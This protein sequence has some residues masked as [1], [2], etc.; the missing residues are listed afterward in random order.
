MQRTQTNQA[1]FPDQNSAPG[2]S[3]VAIA[4]GSNLGDSRRI[5]DGALRALDQSVGVRLE[6][7]SGYYRTAPVGPPQPDYLNACAV[8]STTRSPLE[9]L[10][11]LL[12]IEA[13]FGRQRRERWGPR[14][15]DLDLLL[16][17]EQVV[18]VPR[19]QV[20]HP[21]MRERAFVL[22]PLAEIAPHW[23]DPVTGEAIA[24]LLQ[25]VDPT[26]VHCLTEA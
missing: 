15:L 11:L 17:A 13:H 23:R 19:L 26:G 10:D 1:N 14:L 6:A 7:V 21:R 4:L 25:R 16:Y 5:L 12:T 2:W 18:Q 3:S 8:L 24:T 20:P 22:V 9:L